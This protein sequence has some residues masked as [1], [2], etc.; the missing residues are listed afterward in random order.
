[1]MHGQKNIKIDQ[2]MFRN[3][4]HLKCITYLHDFSLWNTSDFYGTAL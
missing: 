4:S 3:L 1:M 2:V